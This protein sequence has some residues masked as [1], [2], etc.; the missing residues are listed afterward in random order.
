MKESSYVDNY[1][2]LFVIIL[3]HA[4]YIYINMGGFDF[5]YFVMCWIP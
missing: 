2:V 4:D 3:Y 5:S 1:F